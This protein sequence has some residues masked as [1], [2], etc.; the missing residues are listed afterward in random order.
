MAKITLLF[1]HCHKP[2]EA[3]DHPFQPGDELRLDARIDGEKYF[4]LAVWKGTEIVTGTRKEIDREWEFTDRM[5]F[6]L[7]ELNGY[8]DDDL[9]GIQAVTAEEEPGEGE[10]RFTECG[11]DYALVYRIEGKRGGFAGFE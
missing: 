4:T 2:E 11:A 9:L 1:I 6:R 5:E 3:E 10:L 8:S 7:V